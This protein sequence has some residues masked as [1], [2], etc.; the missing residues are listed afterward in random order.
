MHRRRISI[1]SELPSIY[2]HFL[3]II[4]ILYKADQYGRFRSKFTFRD[5]LFAFI[6]PCRQEKGLLIDS[7]RLAV[8]QSNRHGTRTLVLPCK[9]W[10]GGIRSTATS[11]DGELRILDMVVVRENF[12]KV[13]PCYVCVYD[14]E[15]LSV[16]IKSFICHESE[17]VVAI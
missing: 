8:N 4:Q 12:G 6:F 16:L 5:L 17:K 10:K 9:T 7:L 2:R 11:T 1:T 13:Y 14:P 15:E 3:D